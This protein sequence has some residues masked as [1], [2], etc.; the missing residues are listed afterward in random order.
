[1]SRGLKNGN[2]TSSLKKFFSKSTKPIFDS[3]S[4]CHAYL[5]HVFVESKKKDFRGNPNL[6]LTFIHF[7]NF[8]LLYGRV[9][10]GARAA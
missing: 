8:D 4:L 1:M 9:E 6:M 10:A 7:T 2:A 5:K 3:K